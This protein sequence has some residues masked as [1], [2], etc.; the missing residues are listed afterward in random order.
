MFANRLN[1]YLLSLAA[2]WLAMLA[3]P[4]CQRFQQ[5]C[6]DAVPMLFPPPIVEVPVSN[7]ARVGPLDPE[8][9]WFQIVDA[10]DDYF[11]IQNE[12]WVRRDNVQWL[13]GR[14]SSYPQVSGTSFEPWKNDTKRGFERLQSTIQTIRR[15]ASVRVTP[16]ETGYTI[17]VNVL[18][19]KEDVDQA[20]SSTAGSSAQRHDG[21]IVRN[22]N[23]QRTL[24]ETLGWF[25]IGRDAEL[26][27]K[28]MQGIL[29]RISNVEP[30]RKRLLNH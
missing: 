4:G 15:T 11:R 3:L 6:Q 19:E 20:Q 7:P 9:L 24:P 14:L 21:T 23:Q 8:F 30:A 29:G 17:E 27:Q 1:S 18:K 13:E 28:I 25:E 16:D 12:Q 22:E 2:F 10:T 5:T 26:E